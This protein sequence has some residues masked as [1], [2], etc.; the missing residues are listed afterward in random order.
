MN[1][2]IDTVVMKHADSPREKLCIQALEFLMLVYRG[3]TISLDSAYGEIFKEYQRNLDRTGVVFQLMVKLV[4]RADKVV[5]GQRNLPRRTMQTLAEGPGYDPSDL[6]FMKVAYATRSII[7]T[8][9]RGVGDFDQRV[10][11][12]LESHLE[13]KVVDTVT[14]LSSLS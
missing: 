7:V 3:H 9:D 6:K 10:S 2:T 4:G 5:F 1:F 12:I 11:S 8:E 13:I 14:A